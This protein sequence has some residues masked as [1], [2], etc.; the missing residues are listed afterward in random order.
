MGHWSL[1]SFICTSR[2]LKSIRG[3]IFTLLLFLM[4]IKKEHKAFGIFSSEDKRWSASVKDTARALRVTG[5]SAQQLP[6]TDTAP[7][8]H[9]LSCWLTHRIAATH[10]QNMLTDLEVVIETYFIANPPIV[11]PP[12]GIACVLLLPIHRLSSLQIRP[13][14][15]DTV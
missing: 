11:I 5:S 3:Q 8:H 9:A 4:P 6:D 7:S 2:V 15:E 14:L 12:D 10:C 1:F 13:H